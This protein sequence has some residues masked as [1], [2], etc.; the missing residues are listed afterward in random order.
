MTKK[1]LITETFGR[2]SLK[3]GGSRKG[4]DHYRYQG[5]PKTK[6]R[7]RDTDSDGDHPLRGS[8]SVDGGCG[9]RG[10]DFDTV[11]VISYSRTERNFKPMNTTLIF[12][13]ILFSSI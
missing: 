12:Y 8:S 4:F 13:S 3:K 9:P 6:R 2:G 10:L 11:E 5:H 7:S 1:T